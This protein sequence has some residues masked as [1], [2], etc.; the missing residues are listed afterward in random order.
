M[1]ATMTRTKPE[2]EIEE[3]VA[4]GAELLDEKRPGWFEGISLRAL[5]IESMS[6]CVLGQVYGGY[7]FGLVHLFGETSGS[8][9]DRWSHGFTV[10]PHHPNVGGIRG[11]EL[12]GKAWR[13]AIDERRERTL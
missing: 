12:L 7:F 9:E 5:A 1:T 10:A 4:R 8:D 2:R 13:E 3:Y 11:Y 6:N